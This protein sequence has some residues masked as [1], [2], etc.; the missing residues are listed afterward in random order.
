MASIEVP[1]DPVAGL[2]D[3]SATSAG[4]Y[5]QWAADGPWQHTLSSLEA[6]PVVDGEMLTLPV[7]GVGPLVPPAFVVTL[8]AIAV[9]VLGVVTF[10]ALSQADRRSAEWRLLVN[11][12]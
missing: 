3:G 11:R 5:R 8:L 10:L 7:W 9:L 12:W 2:N 1:M 4:V 6:L